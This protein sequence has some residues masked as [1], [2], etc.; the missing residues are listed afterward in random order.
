M[1]GFGSEVAEAD[2]LTLIDDASKHPAAEVSQCLGQ[3]ID[4]VLHRS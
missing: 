3:R 1:A 2:H 4:Y